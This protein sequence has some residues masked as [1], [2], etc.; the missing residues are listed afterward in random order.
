M[1]KLKTESLTAIGKIIHGTGLSLNYVIEKS[2]ITRNR[3]SALRTSPTTILSFQEAR[4]LAPVLRM[5]LD[6]L[7][8]SLDAAAAEG[9]DS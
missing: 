4:Q 1:V 2:G 7:A 8:A 9:K 5:T 6:E 3:L